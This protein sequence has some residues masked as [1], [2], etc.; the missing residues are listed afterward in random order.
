MLLLNNGQRLLTNQPWKPFTVVLQCSF[1]F[2]SAQWSE[3]KSVVSPVQ[4][5][6]L[7]PFCLFQVL[8]SLRTVRN[9][10]AALTNLQD[11]APSK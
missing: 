7:K 2:V 8:A 1:L 9:N 11:R 4:K 5:F 3:G 6:R 10:F